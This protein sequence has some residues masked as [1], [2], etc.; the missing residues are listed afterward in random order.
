MINKLAKE[1][2]S[3]KTQ[4]VLIT[5]SVIRIAKNGEKVLT[6]ISYKWTFNDSAR[7]MTSSS[8]NLFD[9][10]AKEIQKIKHKYR[11]D[12]EKCKTCGIKD[13]NWEWCLE[14]KTLKMIS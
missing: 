10:L 5:K 12:N 6:T 9:N 8:S 11:Y 7:F 3:W 13:I 4:K 1:R 14:Y 2:K